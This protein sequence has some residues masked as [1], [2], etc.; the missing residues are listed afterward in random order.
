MNRVIRTWAVGDADDDA[1]A[2]DEDDN[3]DDA[4]DMDDRDGVVKLPGSIH[5]VD[6][7]VVVAVLVV[8]EWIPDYSPCRVCTFSSSSSSFEPVSVPWPPYHYSRRSSR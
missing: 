6:V 4:W 2:D 5:S 3:D 7:V 1:D 8:A